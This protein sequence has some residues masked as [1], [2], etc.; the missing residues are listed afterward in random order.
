MGQFCWAT[1]EHASGNDNATGFADS[2]F[3]GIARCDNELADR[4]R[5]GFGHRLYPH[6]IARR[7]R[8]PTVSNYHLPYLPAKTYDNL[9]PRAGSAYTWHRIETSRVSGITASPIT[10]GTL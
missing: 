9:N 6:L 1:G 3:W 2:T 10:P 5:L 7:R 8:L 4:W